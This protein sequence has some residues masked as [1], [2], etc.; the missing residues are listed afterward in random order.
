MG[1]PI[2]AGHGIKRT[3]TAVSPR[4]AVVDETFA[5]KFFPGSKSHR[6]PVQ[7]EF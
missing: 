6:S 2:I 3:D 1:I 4:V 7:P 5:K